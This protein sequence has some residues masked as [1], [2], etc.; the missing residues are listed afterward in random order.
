LRR[1]ISN[2]GPI[3]GFFELEIGRGNGPFHGDAPALCS[4][5]ACLRWILESIHPS[6]AWVPFYVC[7]AALQAFE[8][9][10]VAVE[11][12]PIDEALNPILPAGAPARGEC[13]VYVNYFGLKTS[14]AV[15]LV[16]AHPGQVIVDDT[17]AFYAKGYDGGWSFNSARKFFGVP[18]GG[19]AY[20]PGLPATE[21]PRVPEV[22][23]DH[24]VNRLAGLQ[25]IAYEQYLRNEARVTADLWRMSVLSE[26]LLACVE[27]GAVRDR[28]LSNFVSLDARF[29]G[30][31]CLTSRIELQ[32]TEVPYCYPLLSSE[33]VPWTT[34]WG[35]QLFIPKLW[36]EV[37][38]RPRSRQF[39]RESHFAERLL[40]L[41]IDHR[42]GP[43][44]VERLGDILSEVMGW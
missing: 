35:R 7:D 2:N 25:D 13:L 40:P 22:H 39:P 16:G 43:D 20:G 37:P 29:S 42:Y 32:A 30:R 44:D 12:Y 34:L 23:Y 19:Y 24:L 11:H 28:R 33:P 14:T 31:N 3:G 9:A 41:P 17:H 26:R 1:T 15:S 21:Y 36:P 5:R 27:Y 18:D 8:A 10:G 4:G 38:E 6:R